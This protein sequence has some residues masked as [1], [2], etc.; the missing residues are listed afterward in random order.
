IIPQTFFSGIDNHVLIA[1][2]MFIIAGA[3]MEASGMTDDIL[4]VADSLIGYL[5]GGV[6]IST[7]LASALF[8]ALTGSG[9]AA[10]VAI[11]SITVGGRVQRHYR[12]PLAGAIAGTGVALGVVVPAGYAH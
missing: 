5:P 12:R 11:G 9:L 10:T 1:V 2:A 8:A 6:G 7:L 4:E 3:I